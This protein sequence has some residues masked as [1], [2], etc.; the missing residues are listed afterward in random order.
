[1]EATFNVAL[2]AIGRETMVLRSVCL[3]EENLL[4]QH[5]R[6][7]HLTSTEEKRW[8][9]QRL[10]SIEGRQL[11]PEEKTRF[12]ESLT[13]A[14]GLENTWAPNSGAKRFSLKGRCH[15]AHAQRADPP[16]R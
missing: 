16:R 2:Y 8:L 3:A 10:E 14:E 15:G 13:A 1:M 9:Q 6:R 11:H 7:L 12:L 4:R 5:R